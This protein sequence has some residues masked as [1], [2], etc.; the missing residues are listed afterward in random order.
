MFS[1][2]AVV[3]YPF[4][5]YF[6]LEDFGAHYCGFAFCADPAQRVDRGHGVHELPLVVFFQG[7]V[8]GYRTTHINRHVAL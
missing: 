2:K 1:L 4:R 8:Q 3:S 5:N 7:V 6:R